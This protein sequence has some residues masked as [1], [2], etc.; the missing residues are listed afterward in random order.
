MPG[1]FDRIKD[2]TTFTGLLSVG[3]SFSVANAPTPSYQSFRSRYSVNDANIPVAIVGQTSGAWT[4]CWCTYTATDTLRVDE[5][6]FTSNTVT[7]DAAVI[8]S[9][10][11]DVFV[12]ASSRAVAGLR[13]ANTFTANNYFS[14]G[15]V[16]IGTTNPLRKL[17]ISGGGFAFTEAG[18]AF[19]SIQWGDTTG[20]Y[21]V[22]ING[23]AASGTG[24]L[25]FSTNTF[26]NAGVERMRIDSS[27][28]VGIG[29][30]SPSALLEVATNAGTGNYFSS[31]YI[32]S[33]AGGNYLGRKARGTISSPAAVQANDQLTTLLGVGYT[34]S[35]FGGNVAAVSL[36]AAE[37]FTPTNQGSYIGLETTAIGATSRAERVRIDSSGNVGIGTTSPSGSYG[38]SLHL[39]NDANTGTVASNSMLIVES[40]NRNA[41]VELSG[42]A[43]GTNSVQFS[44]TLGTPVARLVS[45]SANSNLLL[46]TGGTNT[47]VTIDNAGNVGI[48]TT[49]PDQRLVVSGV[50]QSGV[51]GNNGNIYIGGA[52]VS[53]R[54]AYSANVLG[55]YTSNTEQIRIGSNGF[56]GFNT[57]LLSK[58]VNVEIGNSYDG[59][60]ILSTASGSGAGAVFEGI[61]YRVDANQTFETRFAGA[62][63]RSD[64]TAIASGARLGG[65]LF[66]GQWGTDTTL[67]EAKVLYPASIMGVAEGSFTA[68]NAMATGISF[69]TGGSGESAYAANTV[70]GTERMRIDSSGNVGIGTTASATFRLDVVGR[71]RIGH[72]VTQAAPSTTDI[73]STAHV[74]LGGAGGNYLTVGQYPAGVVGQ[75]FGTWMQASFQNPTT[76]TYNLFLQ[77]LGGSVVIG[78]ST[79]DPNIKLDVFGTIRAYSGIVNPAVFITATST[80]TLP[81]A[82]VFQATRAGGTAPQNGDNI[83]YIDWRNQVYNAPA[84]I[85]AL[86]SETHGAVASGSNMLF[87]TC[88]NGS[89]ALATRLF[90]DNGG[91]V[92]INTTSPQARLQ[93][94]GTL[95]IPAPTVPFQWEAFAGA[96]DF[97][98]FS[99]PGYADNII[100]ALGNGNIGIGLSSLAANTKLH[101]RDDTQPTNETRA[102]VQITDQRIVMAARWVSGVEQYSYIASTSDSNA[103]TE[104]R[105]RIGTT[106]RVAVTSRG[107]PAIMNDQGP[108]S[109]DTEAVGFRGSPNNDRSSAYTIALTDAGRTVRKGG[110]TAFLVS[111]PADSAVNFPIGSC[112]ILCNAEPTS[113]N[114]TV[115]STNTTT[116]I[117]Y[118]NGSGRDARTSANAPYAIAPGGSAMIRKVKADMWTITG[119]GIT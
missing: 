84:R 52:N 54:S 46:Q 73:L 107:I 67:D 41:V 115:Q 18:G 56:V 110:T 92:G 57:S 68:S 96:Q 55:V 87:Q 3:T 103:A 86:A 74:I 118:R 76:A 99:A 91:N 44:D 11:S 101:I 69:R 34:G 117:V 25:T 114:L 50:I 80:N 81:G 63:R 59:I 70:Y 79:L 112:I 13:E 28:N 42:S 2:T 45:E 27:G 51:T 65:L 6:I 116:A 7:P 71:S 16:G 10:T 14:S 105:I 49:G 66:G 12:T 60:R 43:S 102:I 26:G 119:S 15:N 48:G 78:A 94:N 36:R 5:I 9:G 1:L 29:T 19:R 82:L 23:N 8:I 97:L 62:Y 83:G 61:G 53:L 109:G 100:V 37:N 75:Q 17:D 98:K 20:I 32:D 104:F 33:A 47:R 31:T 108:L 93:I 22:V 39:Y 85:V 4:V 72:L 89:N 64:G 38:R 88:A 106:D 58:R 24:T 90:I 35:A 77:P 95:R 113:G 40:A 30:T 21:P 111:V